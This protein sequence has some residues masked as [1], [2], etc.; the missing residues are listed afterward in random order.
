MQKSEFPENSRFFETKNGILYCGN[1]LEIL[2][3]FLDESVDCVVTSP[4][5]WSLRDYGQKSVV[6]FGD[7]KG[8]LG[9][10][11]DFN[12]YIEHLL[13]IFDEVRRVLKPTGTLWVNIADT[14]GGS[15]MGTSR[16]GKKYEKSKETY[17]PTGVEDRSFSLRNTSYNKSLLLIPERFAVAMVERGWKLRNKI[18]WE[19]TNPIPE[20]VKDRFTKSYEYVYFFVKS[21]KYHFNQLLEP[22]KESSIKRL[23]RA[24]SSTHKHAQLDGRWNPLR[25]MYEKLKDF[26]SSAGAEAP[27]NPLKGRN[28]RDVWR[29]STAQFSAKKFGVEDVDHYAVFPEE[30]PKRCIEAGCPTNGTVLDIFSGT[31][32]TLVVAEKLNRKWIGIEVNPDYCRLA[33]KRIE[34]AILPLFAAV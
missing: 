7:W 9:L 3:Q 28:M 31:G 5:Y 26:K 16:N 24:Y 21:E 15:G 12:L 4:P 30:L 6:D 19:K 13:L 11:P 25:G 14:Y 23:Q 8:Q 17:S 32:T 34:K 18:I 33:K 29:F 2:K 27:F 10:E 1:C 22:V 20:S